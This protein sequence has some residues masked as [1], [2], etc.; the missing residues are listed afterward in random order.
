VIGQEF[1]SE[2]ELFSDG[3]SK[4][5]YEWQWQSGSSN[6]IAWKHQGEPCQVYKATHPPNWEM[7]TPY[8]VKYVG[9]G[10]MGGT[11]TWLYEGRN[12]NTNTS[13]IMS[14][15]SC[16][17]MASLIVQYIQSPFS[18]ATGTSDLGCRC[19]PYYSIYHCH[20]VSIIIRHRAD[21]VH[22]NSF[23]SEFTC[24]KFWFIS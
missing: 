4:T 13:I 14:K 20:F 3:S 12:T 11:P 18:V 15:D 16:I 21:V 19:R 2:N 5:D 23:H 1:F 7:C 24:N 6:Y 8:D 17:P 10:K 22:D 9:N